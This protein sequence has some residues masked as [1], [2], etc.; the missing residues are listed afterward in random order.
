MCHHFLFN[1][2][3]TIN[4]LIKSKIKFKTPL[5]V[6]LRNAFKVCLVFDS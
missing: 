4:V 1:F 6:I 3:I 2:I 5:V